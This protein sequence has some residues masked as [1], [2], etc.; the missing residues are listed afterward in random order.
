MD[1]SL[2]GSQ[3]RYTGADTGQAQEV[4]DNLEAGSSDPRPSPHVCFA[5]GL[6]WRVLH[7]VGKLLGHTQPQT[8]ARY[9]HQADTA[10]PD[11]ANRFA[12]NL[13]LPEWKM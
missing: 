11:A 2:Q 9:A 7:V 3:A 12:T 8:T 6:E 5:P 13:K 4:F 10:V 1:A